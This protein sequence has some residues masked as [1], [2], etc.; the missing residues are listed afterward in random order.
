MKKNTIIIG[1]LILGAITGGYILYKRG[2]SA[3]K[4]VSNAADG[5][6][7]DESTIPSVPAGIES[8]NKNLGQKVGQVL[9][10]ALSTV[11]GTSDAPFDTYVVATSSGNL[12]IRKSPNTSSAIIGSAPKNSK[13]K[14][15]PYKTAPWYEYSVDGKNVSGYVSGDYL[16]KIV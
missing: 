6:F 14:A 1:L 9:G 2:K 10:Q 3:P 7:I 11:F 4:P 15:R 8:E 16:K 13:I 12:N 5:L